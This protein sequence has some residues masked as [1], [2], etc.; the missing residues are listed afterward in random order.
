MDVT[1]DFSTCKSM[2]FRTLSVPNDFSIP[3][4][5][6]IIV[7]KDYSHSFLL[8][9][10]FGAFGKFRKYVNPVIFSRSAMEMISSA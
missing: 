5:S 6:I 7:R 1:S 10:V 2:P 9:V 3:L 8:T 4:A